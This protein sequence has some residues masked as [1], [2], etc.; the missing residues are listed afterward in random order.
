VIHSWPGRD[1]EV[2]RSQ[3]PFICF[4]AITI[5]KSQGST[6]HSV[7]L[8]SQ[9]HTST[10]KI[11]QIPRKALYV[12]LSRCTS[13][14]GLYIHGK[15]A[16]PTPPSPEDKIVVEMAK[17]RQRPIFSN[18]P[19][20]KQP[21]CWQN[22]T[23][24]SGGTCDVSLNTVSLKENGI[25]CSVKIKRP[26]PNPQLPK[27]SIKKRKMCP[28]STSPIFFE[29]NSRTLDAQSFAQTNSF[30]K[31]GNYH[32]SISAFRTLKKNMW[33]DDAIMNAIGFHIV[34]QSC[35]NV[36]FIDSLFQENTSLFQTTEIKSISILLHFTFF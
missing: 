7:V 5:H 8:Y 35:Q 31:V 22:T 4:E 25:P 28:L 30:Y 18:N 1:L 26:L 6:F 29:I 10:G 11:R 23:Q 27:M 19:A 9:Y 33:I 34:E 16:A 12:G 14:K 13:L 21:I 36:H 2:V 24:T 32:G 17:V 3:F 20:D 15:F